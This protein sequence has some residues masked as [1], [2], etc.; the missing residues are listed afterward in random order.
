MVL[1]E[2]KPGVVTGTDVQKLF[3]IAKD[4]NFALPAVNIVGTNSANAVLEAAALT[5]V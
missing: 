4:N 5:L 1:K 3:K 2:I